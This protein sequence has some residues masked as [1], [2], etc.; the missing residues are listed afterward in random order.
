MRVLLI[1]DD[2]VLGEEDRAPILDA[3]ENVNLML[4]PIGLASLF[5]LD[6]DKLMQ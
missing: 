6:D 4:Y 2:I 5:L 1:G 3:L